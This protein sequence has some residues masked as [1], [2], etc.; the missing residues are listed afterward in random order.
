MENLIAHIR[1]E[2]S[3]IMQQVSF[4]ILNYTAFKRSRK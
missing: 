4:E 1:L 2:Q 3:Q